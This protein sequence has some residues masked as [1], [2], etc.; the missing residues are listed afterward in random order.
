MAWDEWEQIKV[1]V[2]DRHSAQMQ[3]NHLPD[4]VAG[5]STASASGGSGTLRSD[6]AA[7]SS[8]GAAVGG[9]GDNIYK[10]SRG[11]M[12]LSRTGY[13]KQL[14]NGQFGCQ[15]ALTEDTVHA[16]WMGYL[17]TVSS[18]CHGL[19][20]VMEEVGKGQLRT[21]GDIKAGIVQVNADYY[22]KAIGS[23]DLND[24]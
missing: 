23:D 10:V 24:G 13:E 21:D 2:A 5:P 12:D 9:L 19:A 14:Q 18:V 3:L 16:S 8:A 20:D 6:K 17:D 22:D 7:W 1:A 15:T 11:P 4:G